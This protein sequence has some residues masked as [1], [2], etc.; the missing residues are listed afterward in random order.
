MPARQRTDTRQ[1]AGPQ[2]K[3]YAGKQ[4]DC[5]GHF[6]TA[7]SQRPGGRSGRAQGRTRIRFSNELFSLSLSRDFFSGTLF[8]ATLKTAIRPRC[9]PV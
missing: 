2:R 6:R 8:P 4:M 9:Q 5:N 1:A 7:H 3:N